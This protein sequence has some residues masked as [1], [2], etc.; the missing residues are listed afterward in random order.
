MDQLQN[1]FLSSENELRIDNETSGYLIETA[2]WAKFIAL[3]FYIVTGIVIVLFLFYGSNISD[4]FAR[5]RSFSTGRDVESAF[6]IGI[7]IAL[8]LIAAV[9]AVTYYFLLAFANK[10]QAGIAT[11][12]IELVNN[13]LKSLKVHFIIIGILMII[14][15]L[16]SLYNISNM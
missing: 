2:K 6:F 15:I 7:V 13:G 5:R 9:V 3:A 4:G 11:E 14:G 16:V 1:D 12:N 10:M 8:I